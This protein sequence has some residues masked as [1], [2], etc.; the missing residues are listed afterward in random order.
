VR[1]HGC[2]ALRKSRGKVLFAL[3]SAGPARDAYVAGHPSLEGR[4]MF[5]NSPPGTPEAAYV[6]RNDPIADGGEISDLVARGYLVR[7][8]ADADTV[9]A[10][11]GDTTMREAALASGAQ[12]VTTDYPVPDPDF[13]TGYSV[14]IPGGSPARCN[15]VN[16][17][18]RCRSDRL[19]PAQP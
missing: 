12:F 4:V 13:G 6:V 10:R 5:T 9:Q 7:T 8:R 3:D 17:P 16:A 18:E 1:N 14:S 15:P 2:P 19:E 11:T